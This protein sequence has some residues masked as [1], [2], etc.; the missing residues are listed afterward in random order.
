MK[1]LPK[2]HP[3]LTLAAGEDGPRLGP[4]PAPGGETVP[5]HKARGCGAALRGDVSRFDEPG[6]Q[7]RL[8]PEARRCRVRLCREPS[9]AQNKRW[10][11]HPGGLPWR[12]L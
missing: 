3:L 4:L 10:S 5:A 7:R 12:P 8:G 2:A 1:V 9:A 11:P 6:G